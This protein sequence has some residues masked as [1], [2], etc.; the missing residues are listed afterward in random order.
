MH[1]PSMQL[2]YAPTFRRYAAEN[3]SVIL[4][5]KYEMYIDWLNR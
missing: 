4:I 2:Q 5:T 3:T 1:V